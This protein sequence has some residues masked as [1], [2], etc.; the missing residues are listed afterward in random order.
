MDVNGKLE[1]V[2]IKQH[3]GHLIM[4]DKLGH[5]EPSSPRSNQISV[6]K[7]STRRSTSLDSSPKDQKHHNLAVSHESSLQNLS[8][9]AFRKLVDEYILQKME[10]INRR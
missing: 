7:K 5:S 8:E 4:A 10:K 3:D 6:A 2:I 9:E 1:M